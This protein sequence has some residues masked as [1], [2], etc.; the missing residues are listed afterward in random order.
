MQWHWISVDEF[1]ENQI[2][3]KEVEYYFWEIQKNFNELRG[4]MVMYIL[5]KYWYI[6][7]GKN[8]KIIDRIDKLRKQVLWS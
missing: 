5:R 7:S 8:D 2:R 1:V 4:N 6:E 3:E